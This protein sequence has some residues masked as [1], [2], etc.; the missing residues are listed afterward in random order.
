M[1][2][3]LNFMSFLSSI[4]KVQKLYFTSKIGIDNESYQPILYVAGERTGYLL[5]LV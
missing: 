4:E 1:G 3:A 5:K 2:Q